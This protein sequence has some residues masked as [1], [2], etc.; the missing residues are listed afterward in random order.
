MKELED[1]LWKAANKLR[2]S[3]SA[4]EYKD[5]V[6]GLVFLK[7][8]ADADG[9]AFVVPPAARWDSLADNA[10]GDVGRL[11]D[12]AMDALMAANPNLD[13]RRMRIG[14]TLIIPAP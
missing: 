10:T 12:E 1:T 5:V 13:P 11:V 2:G 14:Q 8:V 3:L 7:Y 6:L 9:A 4:G